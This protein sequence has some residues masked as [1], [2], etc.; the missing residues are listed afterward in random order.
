[1]QVIIPSSEIAL[2]HCNLPSMSSSKLDLTFFLDHI[3]FIQISCHFTFD[4]KTLK[5][6]NSL[7]LFS[8]RKNNYSKRWKLKT[9]F[10]KCKDE[11]RNLNLLANW[12][13]V[14]SW[15]DSFMSSGGTRRNHAHNGLNVTMVL[16]SFCHNSRMLSGREWNEKVGRVD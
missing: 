11:V 2:H 9:K 14:L 5:R 3:F 7:D 12:F 6:L 15:I 8:W 10:V 1:M 16:S 4:Q 13:C